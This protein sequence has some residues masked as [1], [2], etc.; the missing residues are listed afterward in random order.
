MLLPHLYVSFQD[1]NWWFPDVPWKTPRG[2]LGCDVPSQKP[3]Y[4]PARW[5]V[6]DTWWLIPLRIRRL[7][8][9]VLCQIFFSTSGK[10]NCRVTT[11]T[12]RIMYNSSW[13]A[14]FW[15]SANIRHPIPT[16]AARR[17]K[18]VEPV[19]KTRNLADQPVISRHFPIIFQCWFYSDFHLKKKH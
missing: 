13:S 3:R 16:R 14:T 8:P 12:E 7:Y 19:G 11:S 15:F 4:P 2:I 10:S 5:T 17:W 1:K 6:E 18:S 9:F